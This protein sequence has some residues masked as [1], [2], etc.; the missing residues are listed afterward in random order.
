MVFN[1][2][3]TSKYVAPLVYLATMMH[4]NHETMVIM[5]P[6]FDKAFIDQFGAMNNNI[7][8][9]TGNLINMIP[10]MYDNKFNIDRECV[11][12]FC[13]LVNAKVI[14]NDDDNIIELFDDITTTMGATGPNSD[15]TEGEYQARKADM[16]KDSV[17]YLKQV[18]CGSCGKA[19]IN[20]KGIL[21][22]DIK[23]NDIQ[24]KNIKDRKT[25][26]QAEIDAKT[27]EFDA[28]TMITDDIRMK[29]IRLGKLQ[30]HMGI[31]KVGGYGDADLKAKKDAVEDTTRACE[32]A[33][34]DGVTVGSC[35]A[36][37]IAINDVVNN[38]DLSTLEEQIMMSFY[39]STIEVFDRLVTNKYPDPEGLNIEKD[40]INVCVERRVGYNL[41]EDK[42][43]DEFTVINPVNVDIEVIRASL[44]L[45]II[46]MTSDQFIFKRYDNMDIIEDGITSGGKTIDEETQRILNNT[47]ITRK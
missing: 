24:N 18:Y 25:A 23:L 36:I 39:T 45:V 29:R 16:I 37:A 14:T 6:G 28:L 20:D 13:I 8:R 12:D 19:V 30:C 26:V 10:V 35:L 46:C 15:E 21:V 1:F 33:Y 41:L 7:L 31:I 40:I 5:A 47:I 32:A 2:Q 34:R 17:A 22:S 44:K 9:E 4:L 27:K 3:L 38:T 11:D 42:F 43:D